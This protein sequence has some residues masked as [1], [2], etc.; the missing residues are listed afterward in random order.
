MTAEFPDTS[1]AELAAR[2]AAAQREAEESTG[3]SLDELKAEIDRR[4]EALDI[5]RDQHFQLEIRIV[6]RRLESLRQE[7]ARRNQ[8]PCT[9]RAEDEP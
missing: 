3:V 4:Q 7:L 5:L 2:Q 6:E 1:L 8:P 9:E